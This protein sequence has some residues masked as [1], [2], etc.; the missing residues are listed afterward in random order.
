M[1]LAVASVSQA[2]EHRNAVAGRWDQ[3]PRKRLGAPHRTIRYRGT[4]AIP[5]LGAAPPELEAGA[6]VTRDQGARRRSE[7]TPGIEGK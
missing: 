4:G 2:E 6:G 5:D 3:G 1:S 7:A